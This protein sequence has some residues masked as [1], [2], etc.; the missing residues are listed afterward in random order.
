M[1]RATPEVKKL[2]SNPKFTRNT[3][4]QIGSRG[5]HAFL[6]LRKCCLPLSCLDVKSLHVS[7]VFN[8]ISSLQHK[9]HP[10]RQK[11][12][13]RIMRPTSYCCLTKSSWLSIPSS[14]AEHRVRNRLSYRHRT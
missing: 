8:I 14:T 2:S 7:L 1:A 3:R 5:K 10:D 13:F 4:E 9:Q 6:A 12:C 11:E